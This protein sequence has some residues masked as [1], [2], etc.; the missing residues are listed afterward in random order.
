VLRIA[1]SNTMVVISGLD[2]ENCDSGS[3]VSSYPSATEQE[4]R[5]DLA[6]IFR[7]EMDFGDHQRASDMLALS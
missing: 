5:S 1:L 7:T 2:S 3:Q 6:P 4:N